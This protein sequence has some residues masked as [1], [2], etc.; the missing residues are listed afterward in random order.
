ML[1]KPDAKIIDY[2]DIYPQMS[3]DT[4]KR[5]SYFNDG[6][7]LYVIQDRGRWAAANGYD[8]IRVPNPEID[9]K[10]IDSDYWIVLNRTSVIVKE[11]K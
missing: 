9:G 1:I 4:I 6:D 5:S 2:A 11:G 8:V 10:P 7:P 3:K